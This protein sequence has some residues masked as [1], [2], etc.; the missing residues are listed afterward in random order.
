MIDAEKGIVGELRLRRH[1][2]YIRKKGFGQDIFPDL[3]TGSGL[4]YE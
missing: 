3:E 1:F 2:D 4:D